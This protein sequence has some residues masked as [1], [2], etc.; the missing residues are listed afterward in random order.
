MRLVFLLLIS[1]F[2]TFDV[3]WAQ[4]PAVHN[5][6]CESRH[7]PIGLDEQLPRFNWQLS[8]TQQNV[9]QKA[10]HIRVAT[11]K[12]ALTSGPWA[13]N[14]Q[15]VSSD[16][17]VF[18][19]YQG[20][21]LQSR[22]RYFWQVR[23][24]D[25]DGEASEWSEVAFWEMGLLE[26][27]DWQAEWIR[28]DIEEDLTRSSPCPMLRY[29][30]KLGKNIRSARA[31]I[32][33]HGLYEAYLNGEKIG[34]EL[35][36]PGW[37]AYNE[38]LQYQVFDITEMLVAG[39]N[40]IGVFLADGWYRGFIGYRGQRNFY[41]NQLAL[42][43]QLEVTYENG[44]TAIISSSPT[45]KSSLG[46]ILYSDLYNGEAYDARLEK[47]GWKQA[48]FDD[49]DWKQA[50]LVTDASYDRLIASAGLPVK[51]IETLPAK[52]ISKSPK[53]ETIVDFGQNLV[54]RIRLRVNGSKGTVIRIGHAEVLDKEGNFYT[55][56]L[57][58]AKQAVE[59]TLK[60]GG[61]EVYEPYFSFQGFRYIKVEGYPA[62]LT[63]N[64]VT[65]VV[66]H[67]EMAVNGHFECS[68][69]LINQ[70]QQ[71]IQWGQKG[72]FLDIPTD[73]PQRDERLGWTGDAQAFSRTAAF[74][75]DVSAFFTKWLRDLEADQLDNGK[76][77]YVIPNVLGDRAG[78]AA[79]WADAATIIPWNLYLAYGDKRLLERQF[80]SM[81]AWIAY[82]ESE[83]GEDFLWDTGF[84]FG[85]WLFYSRN[86]DRDG[87]S[88][89]TDKYLLAQA[90]FAHSTELV[91][92]AARVLDRPADVEY[93]Q[94]LL[95]NVKKAFVQEYITPSGRLVSGT[96]T[97]Y[98]L[99]LLFEL[100]PE[101]QRASAAKRLATN[102][103]RYAY[104]LTTGF[105]GTPHLC[106]IL[107]KYGYKDLAYTLLQQESYP[108]WLYPVKM[109][110]TTIWERWDGIR[111]DSTFQNASMNSFNHYAY[112]AIGD[113]LYRVV[114]GIDI[115]EKE[116]GYK[117][118]LIQPTPGGTLTY[119]KAGHKGPYGK[120]VSAWKIENDRF[121]L[122]LQIPP[123]S[124]A[125][126]RLPEVEREGVLLDGRPLVVGGA[127]NN[128]SEKEG[129]LFV[130]L[131]S[132]QYR[133]E[134]SAKDM[135]DKRNTYS[136][137]DTLADIFAN[138]TTWEI[139]K[140]FYPELN[141][142]PQ[143]EQIKQYTIPELVRQS[144]AQDESGLAPLETALRKIAK[145]E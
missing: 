133:F 140:K 59:Y 36:T 56:N 79:G 88:A 37:T 62:E 78:G 103:G 73:C 80:N 68:E 117:H 91:V 47:R 35:F 130:A 105:L 89:I 107:N 144:I 65:A 106:H 122:D 15:K 53:G 76:V 112:G 136:L 82:M 104:H 141:R 83:A 20:E 1:F 33:A 92:K 116:P 126:V 52:Q 124:H 3:A 135:L 128:L 32:T 42:L 19:T 132:G 110:A 108:S 38:R 13:W 138:R 61:A 34:E 25:Q 85:D 90:F 121:Y 77:P 120:I 24:W 22:Q 51:A 30:F 4:P 114:A 9:R 93:Y 142:H 137:A 5:L 66:I 29:E 43:A 18:V 72:N 70:L 8:S 26:R 99:G 86:D 6:R 123:N 113:W 71:N 44:E 118:I 67:S 58:A 2:L 95:Q 17:S 96:Q 134:Y 64:D 145:I 11:S 46:P 115:D 87:K 84:H 94:A 129:Q 100:I 50:L 109:G 48:G 54:G 102:I 23:V 57:R 111:P 60:G 98:V 12:A 27:A 143:M 31:Y 101:H 119:A 14:S 28:P 7:N 75:M 55:E 10:Y 63:P 49:K 97:A 21:A 139:L 74:N 131:G 69:P 16:Q 45:W 127:V 41:G 40:A 39:Q 125:T 81:K